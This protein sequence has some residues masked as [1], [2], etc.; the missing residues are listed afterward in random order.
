MW[1]AGVN[2]DQYLP[3]ELS[4]TATA[5]FE[6]LTELSNIKVPRSLKEA[7]E[8]IESQLHVFT[9]AS[10]EA[11]GAVAYLRHRY[12]SGEVTVRIVMSKA[13]VTPV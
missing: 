11:Y 8:V 10:Q 4:R 6:E 3:A 12:K 5:W 9:D 7:G 2:W 1:T 13:K